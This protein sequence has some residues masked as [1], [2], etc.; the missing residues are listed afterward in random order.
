VY[1]IQDFL[2]GPVV[3]SQALITTINKVIS[4][5]E[6]LQKYIHIKEVTVLPHLQGSIW[7]SFKIRSEL[8]P[9]GQG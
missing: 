9:V 1:Q 2:G 7:Y 5:M 4:N 6:K 8:R 3:Q